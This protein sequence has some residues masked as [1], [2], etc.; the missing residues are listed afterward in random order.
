MDPFVGEIRAVGFNFAPK[1]WALCDGQLLPISQNTALFSL[2]GT[3]YGG[4]GK[5]NFALPDLQGQAA[6]GF[7]T[8][9]TGTNYFLGEQLGEQNVTLLASEIPVHNHKVLTAEDPATVQAPA[10]DRALAPSTPGFAYNPSAALNATMSPFTLAF[11]GSSFPHNN[12]Q[13]FA[14]RELH[15]RDAGRLPAARLSSA[16]PDVRLRPATDADHAFFA[17]LYA[18]TRERELEHVPF[19]P[20]QREAF[21]AQQFA[22][23]TL[24]FEQHYGAEASF[25]VVLIDDEPAGRLIVSR[26]GN[27]IRVVDIALL[28]EFRG[29]GVGAG[30]LRALLDEADAAGKPVTLHVEP[31]NPAQRLYARLGFAVVEPGQLHHRM[32]RPVGGG[33]PKTA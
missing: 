20:E 19:G 17:R 29:A 31:G 28:P 32:E 5:S 7:G 11:A 2:L 8:A 33:Q 25:D 15:H 16:A 24:H 3:F 18:S 10:P 12:M 23:Q 26:G 14:D 13:P 22:A 1:G 9:V 21:L 30:L 27:R 6:V 4:D